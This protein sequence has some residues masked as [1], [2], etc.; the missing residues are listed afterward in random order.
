M[1]YRLKLRMP[2]ASAEQRDVVRKMVGRHG[3]RD[4]SRSLAGKPVSAVFPT[5]AGRKAFR[6]EVLDYLGRDG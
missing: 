6:A 1:I 4:E 5:K 3:G 2:A